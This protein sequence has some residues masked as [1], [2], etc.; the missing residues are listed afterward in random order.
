M[1]IK[2]IIK[3]VDFL[4]KLIVFLRAIIKRT[5]L[6]MIFPFKKT[7]ELNLNTNLIVLGTGPSLRNDIGEVIK[8]REGCFVMAVNSYCLSDDFCK[9]KPEYY[10]LADPAYTSDEVV[11]VG[12]ENRE[13]FIKTV[14]EILTWRMTIILPEAGK[15]SLLVKELNNCK[16]ITF[17][18]VTNNC[19]YLPFFVNKFKAYD[20]NIARPWVQN[21]LHL[22]LYY[23]ILHHFQNIYLY[24]AD[25]NWCK[26]ITV[27]DENVVCIE[28]NHCYDSEH[29]KFHAIEKVDGSH[30]SMGELFDAWTKVYNVYYELDEYAKYNNLNI[31]NCSSVS[32]ID[33]FKRL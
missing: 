19:N 29:H 3:S 2:E 10:V 31:F 7:Y 9:I 32:F 4:Y 18:F 5:F 23:A 12:K 27:S 13:L 17:D 33:A 26:D 21:V 20:K 28:E 1:K 11:G 16:Y 8:K 30:W 15:K 14:K 24:G 22:C 6:S 25:H